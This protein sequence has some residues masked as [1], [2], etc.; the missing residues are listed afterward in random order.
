M[1]EIFN[2]FNLDLELI[3]RKKLPI[4][5]CVIVSDI[6]LDLSDF[7]TINIGAKL[8]EELSVIACKKRPDVI[9]QYLGILLKKTDIEKM[10]IENIDILFNPEYKLNILSY[11]IDLARTKQLLIQWPG[12]YK[13]GYLLYSE[14]QFED[15]AKYK[16]DDYNIACIK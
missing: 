1:A 16:V 12:N 9:Q 6:K 3:E 4:F 10:M 8:S 11:F 7:I 15:Y 2:K 13:E 14:Y 5:S